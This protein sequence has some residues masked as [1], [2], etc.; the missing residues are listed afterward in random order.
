MKGSAARID[1]VVPALQK[2]SLHVRSVVF[3]R[4]STRY[5]YRV[6]RGNLESCIVPINP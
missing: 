6:L 4:T 1:T 2:P 3:I 5:E